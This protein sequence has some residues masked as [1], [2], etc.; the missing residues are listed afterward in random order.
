MNEAVKPPTH[1]PKQVGYAFRQENG[2]LAM[3]NSTLQA[4]AEPWG[5]VDSW[6]QQIQQQMIIPAATRCP[7]CGL[8]QHLGQFEIHIPL[9]ESSEQDCP[10]RR[11]FEIIFSGHSHFIAGYN[12]DSGD[13]LSVRDI[14]EQQQ[15]LHKLQNGV[16]QYHTLCTSTLD[17]YFRITPQG[18]FLE[19]GP[20]CTNLLVYDDEELQGEPF[21]KICATNA[22]WH[23]LKDLMTNGN[24]IY[25]FDLVLKC[26]TGKH[27]LASL[28]A[29]WQTNNQGE[30]IALEGVLQDQSERERLD[31]IIK[32]RT[33][34]LQ[35]TI[36]ALHHQKRTLDHHAMVWIADPK[37][38]ITGVNSRV[39][40]VTQY[41]PAE[42]V[43]RPLKTLLS[44]QHSK[45]FFKEIWKTV[46]RGMI[47]QGEI[48]G[49][50]KNGDIYWGRFTICPFLTRSGHPYRF[51]AIA[52]DIT[53]NRDQEKQ[54]LESRH[55]L[56]NLI[57]SLGDGVYA[58]DRDGRVIFLN[59]E[60]ER[61]LGWN[62]SELIG[63]SLHD[64]IHSRRADG[65][66]MPAED[67]IVHRSLLGR[68]F[69]TNLDYFAHK[70]GSLFPVAYVTAPLI[71][72]HEIIGS[73]SVFRDVSPRIQ[74]ETALKRDRDTALEASR[75]KSEFLANMSHEIRTPMNAIIGMNDLLLGTE[76]TEE[77]KE[78]AQTVGNSAQALLSLI[79]DILDFSKIEAG[80]TD[81]EAV[82]FSVVRVVEDAVGIMTAQAHEKN[83]SLSSFIDPQMPKVLSGDPG[84][85][86]QMLLNLISNAIKFTEQGEVVVRAV[87]KRTQKNQIL[88]HF[89]VQD[90]GMGLPLKPNKKKQSFKR[91]FK[92][93]TQAKGQASHHFGGTGLGLAISKRLIT[94]MGGKIGAKSRG[95]GFGSTFWF[96]IPLQH[97]KISTDRQ[98]LDHPPHLNIFTQQRI[99][100]IL[101]QS[102]DQEILE[103]YCKAWG[104]NCQSTNQGEAGERALREAKLQGKPFQLAIV[105]TTLL[106][107]SEHP[108]SMQTIREDGLLESTRLLA[109]SITDEREW[110]QSA[111]DAGFFLALAKPLRQKELITA[112][113][114]GLQIKDKTHKKGRK[115]SAK[116]KTEP[117]TDVKEK[118]KENASDKLLLLVEDNVVNQKLARLQ[119]KKLGYAVHAVSNGKKAVEAVQQ[120][121]Y[122]LIL[123]DCQMP[124][125]DGF[126]ATHAIRRLDC[127]QSRHIPI[128]AMTANAMKGDKERCL[129]EGM[130]DYLSKPVNPKHLQKKLEYWIPKSAGELP[131]IEIVQ[132]QQVFGPEDDVI[133]ELLRHFLP[134]AG[135]QLEKLRLLC[136][137][138]K[139]LAITETLYELTEVCNNM[140]AIGMVRLCR[141][142]EHAISRDDWSDVDT[143]LEALGTFY[144][145]VK[146]FIQEY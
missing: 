24:A 107:S 83:L 136:R 146:T 137:K 125:M 96:T 131:P 111:L 49:R 106:E 31:N 97:S 73:V 6:W 2:S 34:V 140:S 44:N 128:I 3:V 135:E 127:I 20:S 118:T 90:T 59:S 79:N 123:M 71:E 77:Q 55:F 35:E 1:M 8:G 117:K 78:F 72:Q 85:L 27:L 86:R 61:L 48:C 121:P 133:R 66:Y 129:K 68:V 51:I 23:E 25:D 57:S 126:E 98:P 33:A 93:F 54:A 70:D 115:P 67:C 124:V 109:L 110:Q 30:K 95:L 29:W 37:G 143:T 74:A 145:R 22:Y 82:D 52:T 142:M 94:L 56:F 62:E 18:Q 16:R 92:P 11:A 50:K 113:K 36:D 81:L 132:L 47:W 99:L 139:A 103:S 108:F 134:T 88:T 58:L 41:M 105:D 39:N 15:R 101:A 76:L 17:V 80:K 102:S 119:L 42:W 138:K 130:D 43:G 4:M 40:K 14:S 91:L 12:A 104:L 75:L 21:K 141:R 112:L 84:R 26:K 10:K 144:Q 100:L 45:A 89:S 69:R 32:E 38:L 19:L 116:A 7:T 122:A 120:F 87:I 64:I 63:K 60:G 46:T 9:P 114:E 28:N 13:M 5:G 53:E 65:T